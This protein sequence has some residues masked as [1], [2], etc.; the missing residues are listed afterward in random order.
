MKTIF[1]FQMILRVKV[2]NCN[3]TPVETTLLEFPEEQI[4]FDIRN[5]SRNN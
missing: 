4:A 3:Q 1:T 5:I 2:N